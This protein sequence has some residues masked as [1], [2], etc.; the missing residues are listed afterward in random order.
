M[1]YFDEALTNQ[2]LPYFVQEKD[3]DEEIKDWN[4]TDG[5]YYDPDEE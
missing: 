2:N 3:I 1:S 5:I 4:E